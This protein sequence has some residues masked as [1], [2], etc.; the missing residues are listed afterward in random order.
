M[1]KTQTK[2][3]L[4]LGAEKVR[5]LQAAQLG[6]VVAGVYVPPPARLCDGS[7]FKCPP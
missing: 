3:S 5:Q 1:R 6:Q 2:R 7:S 4:T